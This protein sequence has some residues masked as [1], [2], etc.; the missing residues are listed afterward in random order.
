MPAG[1]TTGY[2]GWVTC[3][4]FMG[5]VWNWDLHGE[6]LTQFDNALYISNTLSN[7]A[8][9][10]SWNAYAFA[11]G[12]CRMVTPCL[13][14]VVNSQETHNSAV[15]N[16]IR[17]ITCLISSR[18][19]SQQKH[20]NSAKMHHCAHT[21]DFGFCP[22]PYALRD[23]VW[24]LAGVAAGAALAWKM[25]SQSPAGDVTLKQRFWIKKF[26]MPQLK[27]LSFKFK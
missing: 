24:I 21:P 10:S 12:P 16:V 22:F 20:I 9:S 14:F 25:T 15:Y 17:L 4:D 19:V 8:I 26:P 23:K 1:V 7:Y 11:F 2:A 18:G 13:S 27:S 5:I 3:L 6:I